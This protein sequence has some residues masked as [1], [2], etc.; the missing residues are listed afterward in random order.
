MLNVSASR[1]YEVTDLLKWKSKIYKNSNTEVLINKLNK[2]NKKEIF[3]NN[4]LSNVL[5]Q[6]E[7]LLAH[8]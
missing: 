6:I 1:E 2:K 4:I 5:F 8:I 7:K 3:Q